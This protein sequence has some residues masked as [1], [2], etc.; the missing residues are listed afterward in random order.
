LLLR[1][2]GTEDAEVLRLVRDSVRYLVDQQLRLEGSY[3]FPRPE[4]AAGGMMQTPARAVIRIDYVQHAAAAMV[5]AL[6][7]VDGP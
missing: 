5:R 6:P 4:E 3:L 2:R 1:R 7:L